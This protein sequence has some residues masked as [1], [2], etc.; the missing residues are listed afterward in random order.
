MTRRPRVRRL[1]L[2]L[3]IALLPA[4]ASQAQETIE[5][6]G[7]AD[8]RNPPLLSNGVYEDEIVTGEAVWYAVIYRNNKPYRIAVDLVDTDVDADEELTLEATFIGPTLGSVSS[9]R[10]LEGSASYN[11]GT[12]NLWYIQVNLATEGRLGVEH[13][14]RLDVSG[15]QTTR[16]SPCDALPDCDLDTLLAEINTEIM[17]FEESAGEADDA[18]LEQ[19]IRDEI[20]Q[21]EQRKATAESELQASQGAIA[22][23]CDPE[24]DCDSVPIPEATT[25]VWAIVVGALILIGGGAFLTTGLRRRA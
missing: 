23:A 8:F 7:T 2:V 13:T 25:P 15:M 11:G 6:E 10:V 3:A 22:A 18:D 21:L 12:T 24:P 19:A 9:G 17:D 14:L 4:T 16:L 1:M 5:T 20:A